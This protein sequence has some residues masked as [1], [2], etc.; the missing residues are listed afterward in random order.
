MAKNNLAVAQAKLLERYKKKLERDI[1]ELYSAVM[2][3]YKRQGH[4][5]EECEEFIMAIQELW[6]EV[7]ANKDLQMVELCIEETGF[8]IREGV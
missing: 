4:T 7:A 1:E 3:V 5:D 6:D 8:D 2:I